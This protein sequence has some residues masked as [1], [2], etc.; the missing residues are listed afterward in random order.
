MSFSKSFISTRIYDLDGF[1]ELSGLDDP[2]ETT[3]TR[4]VSTTPTLDGGS[5][6]SDVG[7]SASD[8][9]FNFSMKG[10]NQDYVDNLIRIA[11]FHSRLVLCTT[12][13]AFEVII[14]AVFYFGGLLRLSLITVG[15]A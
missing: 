12:E 6:V 4:R 1:V 2:A 10:N 7:Y 13:G 9:T 8:R 5:F 3:I 14:K 15:N 11:K